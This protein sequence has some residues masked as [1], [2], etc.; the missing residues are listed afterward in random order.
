MKQTAFTDAEY[1]ANKRVR[2]RERFLADTERVVPWA[3]SLEEPNARSTL[4]DFSATV[5][6]AHLRTSRR[7]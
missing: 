4:S 7:P 3:A 6:M 2:R 5:V 1:A